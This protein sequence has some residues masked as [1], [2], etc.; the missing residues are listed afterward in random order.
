M[1]TATASGYMTN[2]LTGFSGS[3]I[4]NVGPTAAPFASTQ[5]STMLFWSTFRSQDGR[6]L[7]Y[8][9]DQPSARNFIVGFNITPSAIVTG[10]ITRNPYSAFSPHAAT[11]GLEQIDCNSFQ[12]SDRFYAVPGGV[13]SL[14]SGR[15][16]AGLVFFIGSSATSATSATDLEVYVFDA[17][18]GGNAFV[19][20]PDITTG[21]ANAINHLYV[22]ADGAVVVGHRTPITTSSRSDRG[23]LNGRSDLWVC[24]NVHAVL[25]GA[26]PDDFILSANLSHGSTMAFVGEGTPTGVQALIYSSAPQGTNTS[27]DQRTLKV[28]LLARLSVPLELDATKSHYAVLAGG[29]KLDDDELSA[30]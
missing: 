24:T 17:N 13:T 3:G 2:N 12:Y 25:G 10:A 5:G 20:T 15:S 9:S 28:I 22:S 16:G 11:V 14:Q 7:Y 8:V 23:S 6:F 4:G 30:N 1:A 19:L 21:T 27:W 29:R 18:V 26:P